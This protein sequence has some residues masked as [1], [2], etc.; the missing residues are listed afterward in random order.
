MTHFAEK[1]GLC[2]NCCQ[3]RVINNNRGSVFY[4]CK[5]AEEDPK[6]PKYP[7]LPVLACDGYRPIFEDNTPEHIRP[8]QE[9]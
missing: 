8:A 5:L 3:A 4:L 1:V 9:E 2:K 6:F 7:R